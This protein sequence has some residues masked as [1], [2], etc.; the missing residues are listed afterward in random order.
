MSFLGG[1]FCFFCGVASVFFLVR[2]EQSR[3]RGA[4]V[5]PHPAQFQPRYT[6]CGGRFTPFRLYDSDLG[7]LPYWGFVLGLLLSNWVYSFHGFGLGLLLL[8]F[9]GPLTPFRDWASFH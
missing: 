3:T 4:L 8:G 1:R 5:G 6:G 2:K 7:V 9:P